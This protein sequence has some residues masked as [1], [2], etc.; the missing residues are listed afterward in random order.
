MEAA[1]AEIPLIEAAFPRYGDDGTLHPA[2]PFEQAIPAGFVDGIAE[3]SPSA[4]SPW[5]GVAHWM[6]VAELGLE[7]LAA[8]TPADPVVLY[9]FA[10]LHDSQR[11]AEGIDPE[12]GAR[13]AE[14]ARRI[15]GQAMRLTSGQLETVC[16]ALA[17]HDQG[18]TSSDLTVGACWDADRLSLAR[19]GAAPDPELLSTTA[20][21]A[22]APRAADVL[23]NTRDPHWVL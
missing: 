8:G 19:F 10:I 13:A 2:G 21:R 9:A 22:L 16:D 1:L 3:Q 7:L 5:R 4:D 14:L 6:Q 12:H 18:E 11:E 23:A 15:N 20:G 17:G